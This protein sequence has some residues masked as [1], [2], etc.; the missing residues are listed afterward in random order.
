[1]VRPN[2]MKE[3]DGAVTPPRGPAPG[4]LSRRITLVS[5]GVFTLAVAAVALLPWW[6]G[7]VL[8]I[9]GPA[10]GLTFA[11]YERSGYMRFVLHDVELRVPAARI[12]ATR[13]EWDTPLVALWRRGDVTIG[14]W[15]VE[16]ADRATPPRPVETAQG[17]KPLRKTLQTVATQL[18]RWVPRAT[19]EAGVVRWPGIELTCDSAAWTGQQLTVKQLAWRGLSGDAT[20]AFLG[21]PIRLTWLAPEGGITL[22]SH[23]ETVSGDLRW[24]GQRAELSARFGAE[25]WLPEEAKLLADSLEVLGEKLRLGETYATVRGR[26]EFTWKEKKLAVVATATGEPHPGRAVPPLAV[27]L[28]GHGG[29]DAFTMEALDATLPGITMKLSAPVTV[30]RGGHMQPSGANLTIA[31]DLAK[32]PWLDATGSANGE[33]RLVSAPAE[34]P[35][36]DFQL[37]ARDVVA[38][39]SERGV[40]RG[41]GRFCVAARAGEG[42]HA[43]GRGGRKTA[44]E[45]RLGFCDQGNFRR[46]GGGRAAPGDRGPLDAGRRRLRR[47]RLR[48]R[49][50][51]ARW[52]NCATPEPPAADAVTLGALNPLGSGRDVDGR[53]RDRRVGDAGGDGRC[54]EGRGGGIGRRGRG[55]G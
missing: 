33:A 24:W 15:S 16:A 39:G 34:T 13:V 40:D 44:L 32:L 45:R 21:D 46:R 18:G 12:R 23:A 19:A 36:L 42:G 38:A 1:M 50:P 52:L 17:W 27:A 14:R 11:S 51:A 9:V 26:G 5:T 25:G 35:V 31:A 43:G 7:A 49:K 2:P 30:D 53:R 48:R 28:R 3:G 6:L 55:C 22:E 47:A 8:G 20:V 54:D 37:T 29:L 10:R 41:N 4:F